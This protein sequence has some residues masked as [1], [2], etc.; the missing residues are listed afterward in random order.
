MLSDIAFTTYTNL[1]SMF[2][3]YRQHKHTQKTGE[4]G[5]SEPKSKVSQS[6]LNAAGKIPAPMIAVLINCNAEGPV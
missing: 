5:L 6:Q 2:K 3:R 4:N 1:Y